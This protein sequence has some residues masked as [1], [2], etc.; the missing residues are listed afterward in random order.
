MGLLEHRSRLR[1]MCFLMPCDKSQRFCDS[2]MSVDGAVGWT[3]L[4]ACQTP[5]LSTRLRPVESES[6]FQLRDLYSYSYVCTI[7]GVFLKFMSSFRPDPLISRLNS[8]PQ[9]TA[10]CSHHPFYLQWRFP[11][12]F[13][14]P[15]SLGLGSA[16]AP[17]QS[18]L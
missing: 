14:S 1:Q 16:H 8:S 7:Q 12:P 13:T 17:L 3:H 10:C 9:C 11:C 15:I 4:G 5:R 2:G 18:Q 6:A